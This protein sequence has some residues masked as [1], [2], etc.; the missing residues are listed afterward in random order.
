MLHRFVHLSIYSQ[1]ANQFSTNQTQISTGLENRKLNC[2]KIYF[3]L[4]I[5]IDA[6]ENKNKLKLA[7][8]AK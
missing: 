3:Y 6:A 5:G 1:A 4:L 8:S 2:N 7:K